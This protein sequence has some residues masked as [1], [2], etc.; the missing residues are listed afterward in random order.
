MNN[1]VHGIESLRNIVVDETEIQ[2]NL[3]NTEEF[4]FGAEG[5]PKPIRYIVPYNVKSDD[6]VVEIRGLEVC[7]Q[8]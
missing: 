1:V 8:L 4:E 5:S 2:K 3:D 6:V 7:K